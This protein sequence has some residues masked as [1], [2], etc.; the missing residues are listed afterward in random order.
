MRVNTFP[1][2]NEASATASKK[3]TTACISSGRIIDGSKQLGRLN[4]GILAAGP[5]FVEKRYRRKATTL[6]DDLL[7]GGRELGAP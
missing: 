2:M 6:V 3:E 7:R 4:Y 1:S 5:E